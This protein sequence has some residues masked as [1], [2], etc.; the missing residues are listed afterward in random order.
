MT[1]VLSPGVKQKFFANNGVPAAGY[2]MFT[3]EAGTSTKLATYQDETTGSPNT[4]PIILDFRGEANIWIPPNVAYKYV[5]APPTDTDPPTAPIW[6]VDDIVSSQLITLWGGVDTGIVNAYV[7]DFDASF[8]SYEDG[9]VIYWIAANTNT[10]AS[11]INVNGLGPVAVVN[12]DG[13]PLSAS[14]IV[15]GQVSQILFKDTGFIVIS[16]SQSSGSF[17]VELYGFVGSLTGTINYEKRGSLITLYAPIAIVGVSNAGSC[18]ALGIPAELIPANNVL[19][20]CAV[21]NASNNTAS[22]A[23]YIVG[24]GFGITLMVSADGGSGGVNNFSDTG[25]TSSGDKGF[26]SGWTITYVTG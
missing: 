2:K 1:N 13:T 14:Q 26:P 10:G 18:V 9:I 15:A 8:T 4:N 5:F 25:F 22:G 6:T 21:V 11:T 19:V 24:T 3:Y 23:A 17:E 7:L 12:Q 16:A 20:T